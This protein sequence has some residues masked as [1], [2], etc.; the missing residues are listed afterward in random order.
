MIFCENCFT[1]SEIIARIKY[2]SEEDLPKNPEKGNCTICKSENVYLYDTDSRTGLNDIFNSLLDLYMTDEEMPIDFPDHEK[3]FLCE[4]LRKDWNLFNEILTDTDIESIIKNVSDEYC[5]NKPDILSKKVG[6]PDKMNPSFI[7]AHALVKTKNWD[8]F[9]EEIKTK[10]RFHT[11][12]INEEVLKK[13]CSYLVKGYKKGHKFYRGRIS[14]SRSGINISEMGAPLSEVAR[15]GRANAE[16]ISHLY[17]A[18]DVKTTI[19]E[20]RA[21]A[22]DIIT[23]GTFELKKDIMIIDFQQFDKISPFTDEMNLLEYAI[24]VEH[25]RKMNT[26]MGKTLRRDDSPLDYIPTQF[27]ADYIK[28]FQ[29]DTFEI[30][31]HGIEYQSTMNRDGYNLVAFYPNDFECISTETLSIADIHYNYNP[32]K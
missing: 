11:N 13:Y 21:G 28:S 22:Y 15:A 23:V 25:L 3:R 12:S 4:S 8:A 14:K 32:I 9:V 26:E 16:G 2:N 19:H 6:I 29:N 31:Y 5:K 7:S 1:D 20:V 27:I 10:N 24:N 30:L 17:L 18:N